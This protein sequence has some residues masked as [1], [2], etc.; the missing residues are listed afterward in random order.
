MSTIAGASVK[1]TAILSNYNHADYLSYAL[2]AL[3]AQT[4]PADEL[5]V[6]DDAST[7]HSVEIIDRYIKRHPRIR[8]LRNADNLGIVSNMNRGL[9]MAAG[10]VVYFAAA[11]DVAY[12]ALF[13]VGIALLQAYPGAALFSARCEI[14]DREGGIKESLPTPTPLSVPGFISPEL[15]VSELLR[16]DSWFVGGTTLYR[17]SMLISAGGFDPELGAFCDGFVSRFLA[18][19]HGACYAP[20][21]LCGWRRM[22]GGVAWSQAVNLKSMMEVIRTA[23]RKM[24]DAQGIFP[25]K[26]IR[27]WRGRHLFGARRF[28]MI[29]A[30]KKAARKGPI[31]SLFALVEEAIVM[32]WLFCVLRPWDVLTVARRRWRVRRLGRS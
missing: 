16:D 10:D 22:E 3:L 17:R 18:L 30:R 12:P 25:P 31:R 24:R 6:I 13:E 2:D 4:R 28:S 1:L 15:A 9:N 8:F 27:R 32:G 29:Q 26:Y 21:V 19:K 7:D 20:S 14:I 5:I 11:D 23:E